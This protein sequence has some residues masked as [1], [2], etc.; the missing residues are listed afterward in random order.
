M[1]D[2][3][4][5]RPARGSRP[6]P[7]RAIR[8][9]FHGVTTSPLMPDDYAHVQAPSLRYGRQGRSAL[10]ATESRTDT[11]SLSSLRDSCVATG[12]HSACPP[13]DYLAKH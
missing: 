6:H 7:F 10:R 3:Y 13:K 2:R 11:S 5:L 9:R 8:A 12:H 4:Q 1:Y